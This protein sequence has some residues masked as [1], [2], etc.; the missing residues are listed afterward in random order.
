M[1]AKGFGWPRWGLGFRGV[2]ERFRDWILDQIEREWWEG[3]DRWRGEGADYFRLRGIIPMDF[4]RSAQL[5]DVLITL[6]S[7]YSV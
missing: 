2:N 1:V 4:Y 3:R 5:T 6:N 7:L